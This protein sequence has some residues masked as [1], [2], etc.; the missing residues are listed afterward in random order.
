MFKLYYIIY[1]IRYYVLYDTVYYT[2]YAIWGTKVDW[3]F[4]ISDPVKNPG[5][6]D[7]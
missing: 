3:D 4:R 7:V 5:G 1:E 6:T 2:L